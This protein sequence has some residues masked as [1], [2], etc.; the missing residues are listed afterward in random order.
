MMDNYGTA[1]AGAGQ[2][3]RRVVVDEAGRSYVDLLGG[4]AVNSLGHAH[5]AVV[6]AVTGQIATL[7]HVSNLFVAEPAVALAERLLALAGPARAGCS[8]ATPAPR[9]TRPRSSCPGAP[10]GPRSSPP[11]AGSTAA[12]WARSR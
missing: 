3:Q 4:I 10:A 9:R 2:R 7:G 5:P 11:R 8:S 12:R 1:A 6:A